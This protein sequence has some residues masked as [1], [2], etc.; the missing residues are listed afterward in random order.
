MDKFK[1]TEID[2]IKYRIGVFSPEVG[3]EVML[4]LP[5]LLKG[6]YGPVLHA[7]LD[8]VSVLKDKDGQIFPLKMYSKTAQ[9]WLTDEIINPATLN[10]LMMETADFNL[11]PFIKPSNVPTGTEEV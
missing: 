2:G 1:D 5:Q 10:Q 11:A 6:M 9:K 3:G 4:Q 7:C 8:V